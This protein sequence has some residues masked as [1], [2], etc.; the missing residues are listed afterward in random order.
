MMDAVTVKLGRRFRKVPVGF[1]RFAVDLPEGSLGFGGEE[2][3][4]AFS[5]PLSNLP[6]FDCMCTKYETAE[7]ENS[8]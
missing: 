4:G 1:K 6:D 8:V 5:P 7:K 3:A 2:D